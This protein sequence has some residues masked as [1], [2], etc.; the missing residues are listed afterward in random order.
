[1]YMYCELMEGGKTGT[2][3]EQ[4]DRMSQASKRKTVQPTD[5]QVSSARRRA[6][7]VRT[8]AQGQLR[9][10]TPLQLGPWR[11]ERARAGDS[12]PVHESCQQATCLTSRDAAVRSLSQTQRGFARGVA[13]DTTWGTA[14]L[15]AKNELKGTHHTVAQSLVDSSSQATPDQINCLAAVMTHV[16]DPM[17]QGKIPNLSAE[18][19]KA[20]AMALAAGGLD[21]L[22]TDPQLTKWLLTSMRAFLH[23]SGLPSTKQRAA[24]CHDGLNEVMG[25]CLHPPDTMA[26][27]GKGVG[28][29]WAEAQKGAC[30]PPLG[31]T[32]GRHL[33]D[34]NCAADPTASAPRTADAGAVGLTSAVVATPRAAFAPVRTRST[35]A[36]IHR[37]IKSKMADDTTADTTADDP[38]KDLAKSV[39]KFSGKNKIAKRTLL[40]G[41]STARPPPRTLA[42]PSWLPR[43]RP[44]PPLLLR[45]SAATPPSL[46]SL[47]AHQRR[48]TTLSQR[49]SRRS[50]RTCS[51]KTPTWPMACR[52]RP[53]PATCRTG[54]TT[55]HGSFPT[56]TCSLS[57]PTCPTTST[58]SRSRTSRRS[59]WF[60][61]SATCTTTRRIG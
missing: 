30:P 15:L 48:P 40:M 3:Q 4:Q 54:S 9:H 1:M 5:A 53:P 17:I 45:P 33:A 12:S 59:W 14:G 58:S 46:T 26:K 56:T 22:A 16:Y 13:L 47:I 35:V 31:C 27:L 60:Q 24:T 41:A 55:W 6:E 38:P 49:R 18:T 39:D 51:R 32:T 37:F 50:S 28:L 57:S 19:N 11:P 34:P 44:P 8:R 42:P 20:L 25:N 23:N 52:T 21:K 36:V 29:L 10:P 2:Q 43:P 61:R 7:P